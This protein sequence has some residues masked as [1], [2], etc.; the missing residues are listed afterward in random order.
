MKSEYLEQARVIQAQ[1]SPLQLRQSVIPDNADQAKA[2][3]DQIRRVEVLLHSRANWIRF[4]TE[5]QRSLEQAGDAWLDSLTVN[6][7]KPENG[8]AGYEVILEGQMLVRE[9]AGESGALDQEVLSQRIKDLQ[10]SFEASEFVI[11]SKPPSIS[12]RSLSQGLNVLPFSIR[13]VVDTAKAL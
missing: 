6:R 5:L 1:I 13:L 8:A 9:R 10:V 3:R 7:G 12:W 2:I 11:S 4:F